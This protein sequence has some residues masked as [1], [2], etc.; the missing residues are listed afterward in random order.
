M[1]Y[2][3]IHSSTKTVTRSIS[4]LLFALAL[5]NAAPVAAEATA[6]KGK[7][8]A[9]LRLRYEGVEQDN[10]LEDADALT[11]RTRV[12]YKSA[13]Y[14][15]FSGLI[16]IEDV[17]ELVDDFSVPPAGVRPGQFSVI[18]D[19]E[20]TEIDQ[21]FVQYANESLKIKLGR[22]VITLDGHRFVGH[23]GWRQDRQTF[24]A[25]NLNYKPAKG[26][27]INASYIDKRN[28]IFSD[29]AD[30]DS[31]DVLI[32]SSYKLSAGKLVGYAYLLEVD[33]STSNSIDTYGLSFTGATAL[34]GYKFQYAA[35]YASQEINDTFDTDYIKLE[36][37]V[38]FNVAGNSLTAKLAY[39][40]L[41]S[42]DGQIGFATPLA[43]LHKFNGW[44]DVFLA[45]PAQ[46]L[47]DVHV[48]LA[49]KLAGGKW[50]VIYHDFSSD[51]DL[52]G[53]DDLGDEINLV[54]TRKFTGGFSGGI[55][56]ADYSAGD[57]AFSRVDTEKVWLWASFKY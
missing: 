20:G 48:S 44:A 13:S 3:N 16:E 18:A 29:E 54:Y 21:A 46:G 42:D 45:T 40:E 47:Q 35:E 25:V 15:G 30:I 31:K 4:G 56:Y 57:D 6:N 9:D 2:L 5:S 33:N 14:E 52:A 19:P 36:G 49:G 24:D 26:F 27:N 39:E 12:G 41:G 32:N 38:T 43:T 37:G 8:Y 51:S 10:P 11:L 53:S 28:R 22:Q 55:K 34:E 1:K 50:R 17:R 23:V 7:F